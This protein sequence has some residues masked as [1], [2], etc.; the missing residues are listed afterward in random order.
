[1]HV[2]IGRKRVQIDPSKSIGKGGEADVYLIGDDALKLYK[3][4]THPDLLTP[5]DREGA[6]QRIAMQQRKL[7]ALLALAS[8]LPPKV[9]VPAE[10]AM[11]THGTIV[12][13]T[14][15][16]VKGAEVLLRYAEKSYRQQGV[17]YET[18]RRIFLDLH[19]TVDGIHRGGV[20][21]G[22][23]NDLNVLVSGTNC[24]VIDVDSFHLPGFPCT[25]YTEKFVDPLLCDSRQT[26]PVLA[27]PHTAESDWYAFAVMWMQCLLFVGPYGGIYQPKDPTKR[28]PH[29]QR[30][31]HRITVFH[32]EVRYPK[33]A[34]PFKVLPDELLHYFHLVFEKD[35][36]GIFPIVLLENF[37]WTKCTVCGTEHARAV[38]PECAQPSPAAIRQVVTVRGKV[39]ARRL[40]RTE[41]V[42]LHAC[43][44]GGQLL[45]LYHEDG[46]FRRQDGSVVL[47]GSLDPQ[48]RLR[49][50]GEST[51]FGKDGQVI[52]LKP[53]NPPERIAV[54]SFGTLPVFDTNDTAT[55]WVSS[56]RL[57]RS[58]E[59]GPEHIGGV[60]DGQ[61]LFWVGPT[62]GFGFY[63]AGKLSVA[64]VFD[65]KRRGLN[66]TVKLPALPGQ[67]V[68][69]TCT[70]GKDRCW[71]FISLQEGGKTVN[72]CLLIRPDGNV[73]ASAQAEEGDPSWLGSI[74]GKCAA[75]SFLFSATDDGVVRLD[76]QSGSMQVTAGFP[77]TEPFVDASSQLFSAKDGLYVVTQKE[78]IHL[79]IK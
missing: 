42:I 66:D 2:L 47:D 32:K 65:A 27:K 16:F 30:P 56:G 9:I 70:F 1:M 10:F 3:D 53:N 41:G 58:G 44:Q 54:D 31:L 49:L 77:D 52:E 68:D 75:G 59:F 17:S 60:L 26:K 50:R 34:V 39:T 5:E 20:V 29:D 8:K 69:A 63:R 79:S 78:V 73:E 64:F 74:R 36:R 13:Y 51:L 76:V 21:I 28:M 6:R 35:Q 18:V 48:M 19:T 55:Y 24:N 45:W 7:P 72:R 61:T 12:G 25:V 37:R 22:D 71:F 57:V 4:P 23:F 40:F 11:D 43:E 15:P 33:P 46:K 62:F 14:M 38:C 67:L